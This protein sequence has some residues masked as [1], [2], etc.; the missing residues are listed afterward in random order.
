MDLYYDKG[1]HLTLK[2]AIAFYLGES[3]LPVNWKTVKSSDRVVPFLKKNKLP[4]LQL[5]NGDF[6]FSSN[7]I[8]RYLLG[9]LGKD[10]D[11]LQVAEWLD[12]ESSQLQPVLGPYLAVSAS[13]GKANPDPL[14]G[15]FANID[16]TL[17]EKAFL[18]GSDLTAADIALWS[19]LYPAIA[20]NSSLKS[21]YPNMASWFG[22][23]SQNTAFQSAVAMVTENKGVS[24]CATSIQAQPLVRPVV[25]KK[26]AVV[27]EENDSLTNDEKD[28][29]IDDWLHGKAKLPKNPMREKPILPVKG[30]R[31]V[32]ITSALPYVNNV[33]HLGN[34]I[35]CV[36]SADVYSR[37]CK[38]RGYNT[39]YICGTDEYGTATETKALEEKL[40]PKQICD[41]YFKLHQ[42]IYEWFNIGFDYFGRTTTDKQTE[43]AQDIFWRLQKRDFLL[44]DTVEQLLCET[45]NRYLAD[46]FVEGTCPLCNYEDARG[47]QCD[48]CGKLI[49]ATELKNPRCKVCNSSPVIRSSKHL[50][51]DLPKLQPTLEKFLNKSTNEGDWT[52]NAKLITNSWVRDG[53]KPRCI[54]RDLK[55]GTPVPLEGFKDKVFYVWFDAPIGYPS[56][57]ANYTDDWQKWWKNPKEVE[58]Y[59]F[60][61]KDNVPFHSVIFPCSLLGTGEDWTLVNNLVATEYL[62]YEDG[63]FSKSRGIGVFGTDVCKTGIPAAIWRFYLLYIRPESQDSAFSWSDF[64]LKNNS[65]LLNNLGNFVNR[66]LTFL[67][68][69]FNSIV[70]EMVLSE[71]DKNVIVS[72][73]QELKIYIELL[74][75]V[76]IRDALRQILSIS[77]IGNQHL[78]ANKP[79]DLMKTKKEEDR[80]KAGTIIGL[81]ANISYLISVM[82]H[83][84]MPSVS[85][86]IQEQL[87]A[88]NISNYICEKFVCHLQAGH[89]IGKPSPLFSKIEA[90]QAEELKTKFAGKQNP[91]GTGQATPAAAQQPPATPQQPTLSSPSNIEELK[92]QVTAQGEIV[93]S[94][95]TAKA[96]KDKIESE[97]KKLLELKKTLAKLSGESPPSSSSSKSKKNKK[98][99][100]K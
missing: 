64:V 10:T 86:T 84:Y 54:T 41:K 87:A 71:D 32:L 7:E 13:G 95:K 4:V 70:P 59:N 18:V 74:E 82:L 100:G 35:G 62:N 15:H 1:N 19:A 11:D 34:I 98:K 42:E 21:I 58:L 90:S 68:K 88:T 57:T 60:M 89:K 40:T 83:P 80:V 73:T 66:G 37:F 97:V 77:R 12:W 65:E 85:Q 75:K 16:Q 38:L 29:I 78:Q 46:R 2:A 63:K 67:E 25:T 26:K 33:P 28:S 56:I 49:N 50:F 30:Q 27:T 8:C 22:K 72:V 55:W 24:A 14:K 48:K 39:L 20:E 92:A 31:N 36:L 93:R 76:K 51:L 44:E 5:S 3:K 17:K 47:D 61:A 52:H 96:D 94:L 79:W 43:I 9:K 69:N 53:L 81:A 6:I 99:K 23:L 91:V 45:C